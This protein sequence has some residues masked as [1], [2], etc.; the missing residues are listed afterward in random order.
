MH[1]T[2]RLAGSREGGADLSMSSGGLA[3][4]PLA[5]AQ[6]VWVE[7]ARSPNGSV[8]DASAQSTKACTRKQI[9]P[10]DLSPC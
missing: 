9:A 1:K 3:P 7:R 8:M 5:T 4:G 2:K 6:I 10:S